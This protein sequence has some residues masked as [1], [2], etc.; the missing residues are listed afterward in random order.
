MIKLC[1]FEYTFQYPLMNR[2]FFIL[3]RGSVILLIYLIY[4]FCIYSIIIPQFTTK[5]FSNSQIYR[6]IL[7]QQNAFPF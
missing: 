7:Y 5:Y 6:K 2:T 4:C 3:H 1:Y